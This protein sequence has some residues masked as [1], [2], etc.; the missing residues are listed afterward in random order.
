MIGKTNTGGGS[1]GS[2]LEITNGIVKEMVSGISGLR[3]NTFID[4]SLILAKGE[5]TSTKISNGGYHHTWTQ[6]DAERYLTIY[7]DSNFYMYACVF[8]YKDGKITVGTPTLI[9]N[10]E[11]A[12]DSTNPVAM[13]D[14][15]VFIYFCSS[16]NYYYPYGLVLQVDDMTI[17][18]KVTKKISSDSYRY[19]VK[20]FRLSGN[21]VLVLYASDNNYRKLYAYIFS[22]TSS[23]ITTLKSNVAI[24]NA[25]FAWYADAECVDEDTDTFLAVYNNGNVSNPPTY[26]VAFT[27]NSDNT[28]TLGSAISVANRGSYSYIP[29]IIKG[30]NGK[31]IVAYQNTNNTLSCAIL[32]VSG[33]S[34]TLNNAAALTFSKYGNYTFNGS[35]ITNAFSF[36]GERF[37]VIMRPETKYDSTTLASN[38][39]ILW[40]KIVDNTI[41]VEH[42]EISD[43]SSAYTDGIPLANNCCAIVKFQQISPAQYWFISNG[44]SVVP[45]IGQI[46]GISIDNGNEGDNVRVWMLNE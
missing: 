21:R 23:A 3:K 2:N 9:Y 30:K 22:I 31:F 12:L 13:Q 33:I 32:T 16:S 46:S 10:A 26:A 38:T 34:I 37:V 44:I 17:T 36:D 15:L 29:Y 14:N 27:V 28:I 35:F 25:V 43:Y 1:G 8:K 19:G 42:V 45:S 7:Q 11:K 40:C 41:S 5:Y 18:V 39:I 24:G 6:L 4:Y 20:A